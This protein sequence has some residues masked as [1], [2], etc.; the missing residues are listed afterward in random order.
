M[1]RYVPADL[2][3]PPAFLESAESFTLCP[4]FAYWRQ[5]KGD[6]PKAKATQKS[7]V[8]TGKKNQI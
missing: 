7:P 8:Q 4:I 5:V 3:N 1:M 6:V 2:C